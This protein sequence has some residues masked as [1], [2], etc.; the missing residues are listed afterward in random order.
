MAAR[1]GP[2]KR[3]RRDL[4]RRSSWLILD[5]G[6]NSVT[7][8]VATLLVAHA[9]GLHQFG[10]FATV[11]LVVGL[12]Q[13]VALAAV[14]DR[15]L[16]AAD[17]DREARLGA[18]VRL[19]RWAIGGS[20]AVVVGLLVV[21][22]GVPAAPAVWVVGLSAI[23]AIAAIDYVRVVLFASGRAKSAL[24]MDVGYGFLQ[25]AAVVV[26]SQWRP[27]HAMPVAAGAWT[28]WW[29]AAVVTAVV[30]VVAIVAPKGRRARLDEAV[31]VR[32]GL[33]MLFVNGGSQLTQLLLSARLGV[34]FNG[35][36]RATSV[37][38]GPL[39]VL[40][41]AARALVIPAFAA[42][43]DRSSRRLLARVGVVYAL[44][45]VAATG[46]TVFLVRLSG[47]RSLVGGIHPSTQ[48]V[49]LTGQLFLTFGLHT[50]VFY[51]YRARRADRAVARSRLALGAMLVATAVLSSIVPRAAV[52][53][54]ATSLGWLVAMAT[55]FFYARTPAPAP[56][57]GPAGA[58]A[59]VPVPLAV[60][61]SGRDA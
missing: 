30:A 11:Q 55:M 23:P 61:E 6:L 9:A 22:A 10:V 46:A 29:S 20:G 52:F 49:L 1:H 12:G 4:T 39:V 7:N 33:E 51:Y 40:L 26:W 48:F 18:G 58:P 19:Y 57:P 36:L 41:Q 50:L 37:P 59:P 25:I 44:L 28:A 2:R 53:L 54:L 45:C 32:Y 27:R 34:A 35:L 17:T 38:F 21:S 43:D 47:V 15:W 8:I 5:Q 60:A 42:G 56:T 14:A 16:Q 24:G 31:S 3:P 13:T